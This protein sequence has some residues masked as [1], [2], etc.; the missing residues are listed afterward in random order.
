MT[1]L[2]PFDALRALLPGAGRD[3]GPGPMLPGLDGDHDG[4]DPGRRGPDM[5][6]RHGDLPGGPLTGP[7]ANPFAQ[8]AGA[9]P[10][11]DTL[12]E[13]WRQNPTHPLFRE[14]QQLPPETLRQLFQLGSQPPTGN[15]PDAPMEPL[16]RTLSQLAADARQAAQ[17]S[18]G[19]LPP[20]LGPQVVQDRALA[21]GREA[22]PAALAGSRPGEDL[23]GAA[24]LRDGLASQDATQRPVQSTLAA[25]LARG[26]GL[27]AQ[28]TPLQPPLHATTP[29]PAGMPQELAAQMPLQARLAGDALAAG[30]TDAVAV[31]APDPTSSGGLPGMI[32]AAG[33][34]LAAVGQ[35]A[36]TTFAHAPHHAARL[37]QAD[38]AH[39][40]ARKRAAEQD[41]ARQQAGEQDRRDDGRGSSHDEAPSRDAT[42]ATT[43]ART[44]TGDAATRTSTPGEGDTRSAAIAAGNTTSETAAATA[45]AG[46]TLAA[47]PATARHARE[48][49]DRARGVPPDRARAQAWATAT[50][51]ATDA[52][53]TAE[54]R[55]RRWRW[56]YWSLIAVA[57]ACLGFALAL[58]LP[59]LADLPVAQESRSAWRHGLTV[60][61]LTSAAWAWLLARRLR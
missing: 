52:V 27:Q 58:L 6:G 47:S 51:P 24:A 9:G 25:L 35:P 42:P 18:R 43:S 57:Y 33:V 41:N 61:G 16:A 21:G 14:L 48:R 32:G 30:R 60:V 13:A 56:L 31:G 7:G 26:D 53:R 19:T 39:Q 22:L 8:H 2:S 17:D 36:G 12:A 3:F 20:S 5:H 4:P 49:R 50:P 44:A 38:D 28:G 10:L 40:K 54:R 55:A 34:T 59:Q 15:G 1:S 45:T 11:A 37:R 46:H 23:H 29:A